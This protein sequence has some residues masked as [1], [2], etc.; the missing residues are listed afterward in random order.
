VDADSLLHKN[1][2]R[3]CA[4]FF[5]EP[6][7]AAVTSHILPKGRSFLERMQR[8]EFMIISLTRKLQ[9]KLNI[10]YATPGPLSV[11]R[12]DVLLALGGFDERNL[13]EDIEICWRIQRAGYKVKMAYNARVY[14]IYPSSLKAWFKQRARW[15]I[16]GLQTL[17]KHFGAI[18]DKTRHPVKIWH[19][20]LFALSATLALLGLVVLTYLWILYLTKQVS[21]L[22][23]TLVLG[24]NVFRA[25]I[26][27]FNVDVFFFLGIATFVTTLVSLKIVLDEYGEE[28]KS[29]E[30][31][32]FLCFYV[33][34]FPLA[35]GYSLLKVL[36]GRVGW[37]TK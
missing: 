29:W 11:Y 32:C 25:L 15:N 1:A 23:E 5:D 7:V 16:G 14:S 33:L 4:E 13:T 35:F 21:Y 20:P 30:L 9:E 24:G 34:L 36:S 27:R 12:K 18:F 17:V 19:V 26:L 3:N 10:I 2:L 22:I 31:L 28:F 8:L 37:L 6:G